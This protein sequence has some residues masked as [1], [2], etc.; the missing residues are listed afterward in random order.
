MKRVLRYLRYYKK[1]AVLGPLFKLMEAGVDL[2]TPFLMARI[3]DRGIGTR[4]TGYIVRI[5]LLLMVLGAVG[6]AL[7]VV[8][9]Y[10]SAKAAVGVAA[11]VRRSLFETVQRLSFTEL[12]RQGSSSLMTR[13][14]SDVNQVQNGLNLALRLLLRSPFIVFGAAA[15]ALLLDVKSMLVFLIAI[16]LLSAVV[17]AVL[18]C[19]LPLYRKAQERLDTVTRYTRETLTGV[20]VLRAFGREPQ[21]IAAFSEVNTALSRAQQK[22]GRVTALMNPLTYVLINLA[23]AALIYTGA[24]RVE[25]GLLTQGAV[26]ALYNYMAQIL[27]ELI[28]LANLIITIT[29]SVACARRV[30]SVLALADEP[31]G[32]C[33]DGGTAA[34]AAT[35][36]TAVTASAVQTVPV[37]DGEAASDGDV[38]P[39]VVP[40]EIPPCGGVA[41]TFEGVSFT[42]AGAAAP[43]LSGVSFAAAPGETVGIIGGTGSGKSTLINLIPR[44]YEASEGVVRL[45]G[46]DV[47]QWT[48]SAL[49]G[50]IG[51]VPQKAV[52]FQGTIRENLL[53][54]NAGADDAT[55]Q[56]ALTAAQAAQ[57]VADKPAGM[58][59][60]VEQGGRNFSGGQR[61]RL[62]IA[63]ALVKRPALLILDDSAS[64]LDYA[65]EARL[66]R[67]LRALPW[68]PTVLIISQRTSSL[69]HADRIVV[70]DDGVQVGL[71]THEELLSSC[72]V[73][74][75]I[76]L[77]QTKEENGHV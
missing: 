52:L 44:F 19:S 33:L 56:E 53:W 23:I 6:L 10:F 64:A 37:A 34:T 71:G 65:T 54:G 57:V 47:R 72:P 75:E 73:Y 3:I 46:R 25:A 66:R 41:L 74:R 11:R 51:L 13:M 61:Q 36:A 43:A 17:F 39:A 45:D 69:R 76:H 50:V 15:M 14:T 62:T 20:R 7:A 67:A 29:R 77:S 42:Y 38:S 28:K 4:D 24:L 16:P 68:H 12:D 58:D 49:R 30:E 1:E 8:A 27:V 9:Q 70:L 31:G 21:E 63:R 40:D 35:V 2:L 18:L 60:P 48:L 22:A 26:V 32:A 5:S 59:A 55:L